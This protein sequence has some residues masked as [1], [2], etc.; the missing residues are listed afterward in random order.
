MDY[1]QIEQTCDQEARHIN[2]TFILHIN[3]CCR[4]VLSSFIHML[5][6][7]LEIGS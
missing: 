5:L 2:D 7:F 3:S 4:V 6:V 1:Y